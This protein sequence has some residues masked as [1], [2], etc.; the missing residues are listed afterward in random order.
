MRL[1]QGI[2]AGPPPRL[3]GLDTTV[4]VSYADILGNGRF[5]RLALSHALTF[6]ALLTFVASSPQL[7]HH[8]IGLGASAFASLQV[9]GVMSFMGMAS[10]SVRCAPAAFSD[11]LALPPSQMGRASAMMTL[12]LLLAGALCTQLVAPFMDG[13][14]AVP[15]AIAMLVLCAL[16]LWGVTPYPG[17]AQRP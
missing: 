10:Q 7:M 1:L 16:S 14:S 11:A 5:L 9:L 3:P 13:A 17:A 2:A 15:L 12:A 6:G 4:R 8:A